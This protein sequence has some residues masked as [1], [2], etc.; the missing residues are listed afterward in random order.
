MN[1]VTASFNTTVRQ[2][3]ETSQR[4]K[5][6]PTSIEAARQVCKWKLNLEKCD[7]TKGRK[8]TFRVSLQQSR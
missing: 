2:M 1:S 8:N 4:K 3:T 5:Q 6:L 7:A